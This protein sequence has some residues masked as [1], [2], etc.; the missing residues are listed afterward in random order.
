MILRERETSGAVAK[1]WY[2]PPAQ[3]GSSFLKI[4]VDASAPTAGHRLDVY[5]VQE[6]AGSGDAFFVDAVSVVAT[7]NVPDGG[8]GE[9]VRAPIDAADVV[10]ATPSLPV[11]P[12]GVPGNWKILFSD[13]FDGTSLDTSKWHPNWFGRTDTSI[14]LP[15]NNKDKPSENCYDPAQ[16]S[17]A[18]GLL[19]LSAAERPC[20]SYPFASGMISSNGHFSYTYGYQEA[21]MWLDGHNWPAFWS[22]GHIWPTNGEDDTIELLANG[23]LCWHFHSDA[24][25]PGHCTTSIDPHGWHTFGSHW[26]PGRVDYYYDGKHVGAITT[27]ITAAPMYLIVNLEVSLYHGAQPP[28]AS[29]LRVD[30]VRVWQSE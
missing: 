26:Q 11:Q 25:G 17:V 27:G 7:A 10:D 19:T 5:I 12:V 6:D 15:V 24:G 16:V 22:D 4:S 28:Q 14:T 18:E 2:S 30:Y 29:T 3:L 20:N 23:E 21:R 1:L 9:D 13:E 8:S